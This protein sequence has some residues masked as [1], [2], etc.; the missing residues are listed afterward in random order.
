MQI[1]KNGFFKRCLSVVLTG[2]MAVGVMSAM[3]GAPVFATTCTIGTGCSAGGM[4]GITITPGLLS[5]TTNNAVVNNGAA[6]VVTGADQTIPFKFLTQVSDL[7]GL[8]T[9]AGWHVTAS[10]TAVTFGT[11]VSSD[12]FLDPNLPVIVSCAANASCVTAG[13]V[14]AAA[15]GDLV[16]APIKLVSAAATGGNHGTFSI[17]TIGN[18]NLPSSAGPVDTGTGVISVTIDTAP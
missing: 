15:G 3:A 2:S 4:G 1:F 13:L 6:V 11:G 16:T 5:G 17:M 7:R 14:L 18:F 9:G 8:S 10:A 12:L